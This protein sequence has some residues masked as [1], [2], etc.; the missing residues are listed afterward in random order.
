[1]YSMYTGIAQIRNINI[2]ACFTAI[3]HKNYRE[4]L[5]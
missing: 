2:E 1:M 5:V 3:R 4:D